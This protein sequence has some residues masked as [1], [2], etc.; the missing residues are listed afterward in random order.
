MA[1][2]VIAMTSMNAGAAQ[3]TVPY[4]KFTLKNGMRVI[5]SR[6]A[7]VPVAAVYVLYGVGARSEE[8]GRTGFAHLFEHMMFQGSK[9]A[10]KGVHFKTVESNGGNLNGSTHPDYT[11]YFEMLP[12]NKVPVALWLESDRMRQ[13]DINEANL[14]NQKDAVK[15]ERRLSFDNQPYNTA[16]VDKWP[17]LVFRNW[18]NSHSLIGSFE[19]LNAATVAD[20]S[21]FF[22]TFYAPN[23]AVLAIVGDISIPETRKL[24]E[25][26]FAD[27]PPQP[28]PKH[29]DLTE[30]PVTAPRTE[31]Y[32]DPLAPVP[33]VAIG[34]PGPARRSTDYYALIMADALLTMGESSRLYLSLVKGKQSVV[35]FE[36]NPGWPFQGATDYKDP[37]IYGIFLLHKPNFAAAQIVSQVQEEFDKLAAKGV[38]TAELERARTQLRA[39]RIKELQSSLRRATLL[40]QYEMFDGRPDWITEELD[41]LMSVTP[42]EI[43]SAAKKYLTAGSRSVLEIALAP[44]SGEQKKE[45]GK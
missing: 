34:Y 40:A 18:H 24:V 1:G 41:K 29:P 25:F 38:D 5:L 14:T 13:L 33:G 12:S 31:V 23:N 3:M 17:E 27:I 8:K 30:P 7:A 15:Q 39:S 4:E 19:D 10:P 20:V 35:R 2:I 11:D 22:R 28:Q 42:A 21:K 16:I 45:E 32:R 6:D 26:Y 37:N 44:K 9:N 43:Q 36:A